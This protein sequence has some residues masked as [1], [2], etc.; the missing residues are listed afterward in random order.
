[1]ILWDEDAERALMKL[2]SSVRGTVR[3]RIEMRAMER[4]VKVITKEM[5]ENWEDIVEV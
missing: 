5:I 4:G 1:M 3:R 2:P